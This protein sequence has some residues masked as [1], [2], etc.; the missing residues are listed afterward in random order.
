VNNISK[1]TKDVDES[2]SNKASILVIVLPIIGTIIVV[3][4][5]VIF[6]FSWNQKQLCFSKFK[7]KVDEATENVKE[8][9]DD[10]LF[11]QYAEVNRHH[12]KS[13]DQSDDDQMDENGDD[14]EECSDISENE[15]HNN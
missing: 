13:D 6:V 8:T 11:T 15:I 4:I 7:Y 2:E 14:D 1:R 12:I 5:I 3:I 9:P 10:V